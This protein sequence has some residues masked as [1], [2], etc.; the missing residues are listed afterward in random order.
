M[1]ETRCEH[2]D[3]RIESGQAETRLNSP[4]YSFSQSINL[5]QESGRLGE[6]KTSRT[7]DPTTIMNVTYVSLYQMKF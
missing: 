7:T 1:S 2:S 3:V 5:F 4:S 6:K